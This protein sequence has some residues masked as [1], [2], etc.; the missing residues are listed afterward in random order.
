MHVE[1]SLGNPDTPWV[2]TILE[3]QPSV[4]TRRKTVSQN[5]AKQDSPDDLSVHKTT[6]AQDRIR[7]VQPF[8]TAD[9]KLVLP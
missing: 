7:C 6:H 2:Q 8:F 3:L 9:E 4:A 1:L 5:G